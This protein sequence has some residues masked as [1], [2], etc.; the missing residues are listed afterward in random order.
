MGLE[1]TFTIQ[2][3]KNGN[4]ICFQ[5]YQVIPI[6]TNLHYHLFHLVMW[7]QQPLSLNLETTWN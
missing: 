7:V 3:I 5:I 1:P 4:V 2:L 6:F